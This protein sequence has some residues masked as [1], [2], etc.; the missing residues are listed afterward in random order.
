MDESGWRERVIQPF[1][2]QPPARNPTQILVHNS[3]EPAVCGSIALAP[4]H[5]QPRYIL[6]ATHPTVLVTRF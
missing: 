3:H 1:G 4:R 2:A 5:E 6:V